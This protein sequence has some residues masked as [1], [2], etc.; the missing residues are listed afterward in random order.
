M[1][2]STCRQNRTRSNLIHVRLSNEKPH[3]SF[4]Q[5]VTNVLITYVS[6]Q[7]SIQISVLPLQM[8]NSSHLGREQDKYIARGARPIHLVSSSGIT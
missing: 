7:R 6:K 5:Q 8:V 2:I 1:F 3:S 4:K